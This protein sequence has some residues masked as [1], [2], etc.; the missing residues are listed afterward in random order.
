MKHI[1]FISLLIFVFKISC[2]QENI[3]LVPNYS[4]ENGEINTYTGDPYDP[5][6][7]YTDCWTTGPEPITNHVK[8]WCVACQQISIFNMCHNAVGNTPDWF[9]TSCDDYTFSL[10]NN[11]TCNVNNHDDAPTNKFM[12]L[13]HHYQ[14]MKDC[15]GINLKKRRN[16]GRL[17]TKVN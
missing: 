10:P 4:F 7:N 3:N 15:E 14:K 16:K 6:C 13:H 2:A 11:N 8:H 17:K 12:F 9:S 5:L 1:L